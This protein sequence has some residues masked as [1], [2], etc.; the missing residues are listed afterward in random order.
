MQGS[1]FFCLFC[2]L[3]LFMRFV[4]INK[5]EYSH[6]VSS[7]PRKVQT[8]KRESGENPER[9]EPPYASKACAETKV[10]HWETEKAGTRRL[11]IHI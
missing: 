3:N 2:V 7:L 1:S 8:V 4:I 11:T 9:L 10:G 5:K 6:K